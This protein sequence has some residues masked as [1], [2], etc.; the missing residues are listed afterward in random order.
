MSERRYAHRGDSPMKIFTVRQRLLV[1][2]LTSAAVLPRFDAA[3]QGGGLRD[4][5]IPRDLVE[6]LVSSMSQG[7]VPTIVVGQL[8]QS[9]AGKVFVPA[10]ARILGGTYSNAGAT[11]ILL[12][13]ESA[14]SLSA[15][16]SRELPKLGWRPFSPPT[17]SSF[18][19]WGFAD[20]PGRSSGALVATTSASMGQLMGN[21]T[22]YCGLG[23]T[24]NVQIQPSGLTD[25]RIRMSTG[26]SD[27]CAIMQQQQV[28]MVRMRAG[29]DPYAASRAP[30]LTN[31]ANA[32]DIGA[33]PSLNQTG[34]G[35]TT[36]LN[37]AMTPDEL[38]AFYA[39]Q[40]ADSGWTP[41][42]T[43]TAAREWTRTDSAG[44]RQT[45]GLRIRIPSDAPNCREIDM[46]IRSAIK[47]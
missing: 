45:V 46:D 26:G 10:S 27:I 11:A 18:M 19:G 35:G 5:P 22:R 41:S 29:G 7:G 13:S 12:S 31:P 14:D 8:P 25:Q 30:A 9:M 34:P 43:V 23:S 24:L 15:Q 44:N 33:C 37:T 3:A 36:R 6:A 20:P 42:G 32:R 4:Q 2:A 17:Q 28:E 38:I 1:A 40:L 47:R 16:L 21:M 39:K